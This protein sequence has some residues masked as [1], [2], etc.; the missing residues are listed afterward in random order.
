MDDS[1]REWLFIFLY[2]ALAA[3]GLF[4]SFFWIDVAKKRAALIK[5]KWTKRSD[6]YWVLSSAVAALALGST[7]LFAFR[8]WGNISYGL[9][10]ILRD[11]WDGIGV[12]VGLIVMLTGKYMLVWL[13]DLE[14]QPPIWTW[15]RWAAALLIA[16]GFAAVFVSTFIPLWESTLG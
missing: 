3:T 13:A 12:G 16:W 9:S 6:R 4:L 2:G 10:P 5:D 11:R 15:T 14:K 8:L 7:I 1:F